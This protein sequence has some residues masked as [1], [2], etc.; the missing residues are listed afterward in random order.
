MQ[1]NE[2]DTYIIWNHPWPISN[3][4]Q[5]VAINRAIATQ[6]NWS[7][8]KHPNPRSVLSVALKF[9]DFGTVRFHIWLI[10][11]DGHKFDYILKSD[12]WQILFHEISRIIDVRL[13][14]FTIVALFGR[15]LVDVFTVLSNDICKQKL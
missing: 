11:R 5:R 12:F 3:W 1:S 8:L 4:L 7:I 14:C 2:I 6:L 13:I 10:G 9:D 15:V